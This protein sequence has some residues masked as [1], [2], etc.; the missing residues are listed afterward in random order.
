M[1]HTRDG[2]DAQHGGLDGW[3]G[4]FFRHSLWRSR[5]EGGCVRAARSTFI[6]L[7]NHSEKR[8]TLPE[9]FVCQRKF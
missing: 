5:D 2:P 3:R 4:R 8:L 6:I 1:L 9:S 7:L